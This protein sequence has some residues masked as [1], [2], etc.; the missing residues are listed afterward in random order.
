MS[1]GL[2]RI[3]EL[4]GH[5]IGLDPVAVGAHLVLRA[6]QRRM[7]E[8]NLGDLETYAVRADQNESELQSLIEEVVVPESWFFR[9][10]RPFRW[11][12]DYARD[13]WL[14][15]PARPPLRVLSLACAGGEEPYSI[16]IT[17]RDLGLPAHRFRID[18]VDV[19][20]RRLAVA[21]RGVYSINAF[22][23]S[24]LGGRARHFREH[25]QGYE[26]DPA[27]R[28]TVRFIQGNVLDPKLLADSPPYD[29]VFCRNLLIYLDASAR[30]RVVAALD[31]VLAADG[32]LIIGHA[33][34]LELAGVAPRFA[35]VG[36]PGCFAYRKTTAGVAGGEW[37]VAGG[38]RSLRTIHQEPTTAEVTGAGWRAAGEDR[39]FTTSA[40]GLTTHQEPTTHH[41]TPATQELLEQAAELAN[42]GRHAE[43]IAAC[44]RHL[45]LK[46]PSAVA[47]Y[48]MGMICQAAGDRR[49]AEDCF[50]KTVY[51]DPKHED[52]LLALALLAERR[53]DRD[54]AARF[55]RRARHA[56]P[57]TSIRPQGRDSR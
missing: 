15:E 7:M 30:A 8:L 5:R 45:Q 42:Q 54:A 26:L 43:A 53:G 21:R 37:R 13:G 19:S 56:A 38:D 57:S 41:P 12:G 51:L 23:G 14:N 46:G 4:L 20:A 50:H 32:V 39:S 31:R 36:E 16:A 40:Q 22:R 1:G 44:Q 29:V 52:A 49:R 17:L 18:A 24:Q 9:D 48:L 11:L 3:L 27:I 55:R 6:A 28:A 25:P 47:Y 2:R 10:E 35:A 33:D 34:R